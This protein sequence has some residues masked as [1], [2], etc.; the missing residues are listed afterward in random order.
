VPVTEQHLI[1]QVLLE[2]LQPPSVEH[3]S[4]AVRDLRQEVESSHPH[5]LMLTRLADQVVELTDIIC[6]DAIE[7]GDAAG[8]DRYTN[9]I[10]GRSGGFARG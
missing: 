6:F 8:F 9:A 3:V 5:M 7:R 2:E 10:Y 1:G 4:R